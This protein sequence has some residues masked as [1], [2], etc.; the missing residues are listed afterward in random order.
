MAGVARLIYDSVMRQRGGQLDKGY[1]LKD[2]IA[3][4][5]SVT[6]ILVVEAMLAGDTDWAV[7]G[8]FK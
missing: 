4:S 7:T 1:G 6:G 2:E 5:P 3:V 8:V